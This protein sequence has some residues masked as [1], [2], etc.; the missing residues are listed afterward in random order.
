MLD[1]REFIQKI[2]AIDY[3]PTNGWYT[4]TN[5]R[6]GFA[7]IA[8][9]LDKFL[10]RSQWIMD[11]ILTTA[12]MLPYGVSDHHPVQLV[13]GSKVNYGGGS[14]FKVYGGERNH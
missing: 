11:A 12:T 1:F 8:E 6:M 4:W 5:R 10:T 3:T 7:N 14:S 13:I 2:N 9:R